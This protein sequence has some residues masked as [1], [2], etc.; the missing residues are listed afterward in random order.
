[1]SA[2]V[3]FSRDVGAGAAVGGVYAAGGDKLA[4]EMRFEAEQQNWFRGAQGEADALFE[5]LEARKRE[6]LGYADPIR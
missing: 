5:E 6:R 2:I 4:D 3:S 1:M